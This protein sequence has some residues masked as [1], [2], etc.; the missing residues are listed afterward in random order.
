MELVLNLNELGAE[1]TRENG[2]EGRRQTGWVSW[3]VR[4][5]LALAA[6][7]A[8]YLIMTDPVPA[9]ILE[10]IAGDNGGVAVPGP[11][12]TLLASLPFGS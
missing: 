1:E 2:E 11:L 6:V 9:A 7:T 12:G 10:R 5:A 4:I 3:A 8:A